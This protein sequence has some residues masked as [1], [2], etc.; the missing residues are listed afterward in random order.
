MGLISNFADPPAERCGAGAVE[1]AAGDRRP[2]GKGLRRLPEVPTVI[3]SG[4]TGEVVK[5]RMSPAVKDSL[6]SLIEAPETAG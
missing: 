1:Q 3:E 4:P 2:R 5:E 6:R